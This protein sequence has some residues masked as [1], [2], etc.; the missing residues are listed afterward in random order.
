MEEQRA[1]L[2]LT[3]ISGPIGIFVTEYEGDRFIFIADIHTDIIGGI[4]SRDDHLRN[5]RRVEDIAVGHGRFKTGRLVGSDADCYEI[6]SFLIELFNSAVRDK[7]FVDFYHEIPYVGKDKYIERHEYSNYLDKIDAVFS[8]CFQEQKECRLN[9]Y[10]RF[11]YADPRL[12]SDRIGNVYFPNFGILQNKMELTTDNLFQIDS[13]NLAIILFIHLEEYYD[14]LL[15]SDNFTCDLSDFYQ[16]IDNYID[17]H[18]TNPEIAHDM[19]RLFNGMVADQI[20]MSKNFK[21]S[22]IRSQLIGLRDTN[23]KI[24]NLLTKWMKKSIDE[25]KNKLQV[26]SK[27]LITDFHIAQSGGGVIGKRQEFITIPG[28]ISFHNSYA[29]LIIMIEADVL[30]MDIYLLARLFRKF[31]NPSKTKI[32]SAGAGHIGNYLNFFRDYLGVTGIG[33]WETVK[34]NLVEIDSGERDFHENERCVESKYDSIDKFLKRDEGERKGGL[35]GEWD[36]GHCT[37]L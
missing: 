10:V 6:T 7:V 25:L 24:Y 33:N 35:Y 9:P 16:K 26:S 15:K 3:H 4:C 1:A 8:S 37:I 22:R 13:N 23:Y 28:D 21:I 19:K 20:K 32:I 17:Q 31:D 2:T 11:H 27:L 12:G 5:C 30:I 29:N 36:D 18:I 34:K 14:I